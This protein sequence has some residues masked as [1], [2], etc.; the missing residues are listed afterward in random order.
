MT[1]AKP[2][3]ATTSG[4]GI[5]AKTDSP[6]SSKLFVDF[7]LSSEGQKTIMETGRFSARKD[8][9]T[10]DIRTYAVPDAVVLNLDKYLQEFTQ[11]FRPQ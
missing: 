2:I 10:V 3:V 5:S 9:Q 1:S 11:L 8:L 4:I 6:A 7:A